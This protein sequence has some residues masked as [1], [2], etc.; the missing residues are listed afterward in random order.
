M[1]RCFLLLSVLALSACA[2]YINAGNKNMVT[3]YVP[4]TWVETEAL[5]LADKHCAEYGKAANLRKPRASDQYGEL[6]DYT[7]VK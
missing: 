7:C 5:A 2:P 6:Y 1:V 3:V 4:N